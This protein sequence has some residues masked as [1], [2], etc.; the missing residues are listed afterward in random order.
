MKRCSLF[1]AGP[2]PFIILPLLL[3]GPLLFFKWHAIEKDV[4][5]NAHN[6]LA[7]I[8]SNWA[9]IETTNRGRN[10]LLTGTPPSDAA[11]KTAKETVENSYGVHKVDISSDVAPLIIPPSNPELNA[12]VTGESVVLRGTLA[13]QMDIDSMV[14]KAEVAFGKDKVTNKLQ[15][16]DNTATLPKLE[17]F[18][19]SLVGKSF[20][21]ETL[22][23]SI[24]D[25]AITLSGTV[26]SE[27]SNSII[28]TQIAA[29]S[30]LDITNK[31][32]VAAPPAPPQ[33]TPVI[34]AIDCQ[35]TVDDIL[36]ASKISFQTGKAAIHQDSFGLLES[37]KDAVLSCTDT[38]FEVSGHTDSVGSLNFNMALSER[39]AQAVVDHLVGLGLDTS[40]LTSAGYG[41][42]KPIADNTTSTGR[43]QNRRIEFKITK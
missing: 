1:C 24:K 12:I 8:G 20:G 29:S 31:L 19:A 15:I 26:N 7:S 42:N 16:G 14:S 23:A 35:R 17:G 2:W 9:N 34:A 10:V 43:A 25:N 36:S 32:S 11:I 37:I 6:D 28:A 38:R 30:K 4:A 27:E 3:L 18:F 39:R 40:R 5:L 22:T 13:H 33:V 21:L 41:P